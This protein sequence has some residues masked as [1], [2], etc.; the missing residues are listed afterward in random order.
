MTRSTVQAPAYD[1]YFYLDNVLAPT[2]HY[3]AAI[4]TGLYPGIVNFYFKYAKFASDYSSPSRFQ[5]GPNMTNNSISVGSPAVVP[6]NSSLTRIPVTVTGSTY[7][8]CNSAAITYKVASPAPNTS[9]GSE[10]NLHLYTSSSANG[11]TKITSSNPN[12]KL[13]KCIYAM[14]DVDKNGHVNSTDSLCIQKRYLDLVDADPSRTANEQEI[15]L[16]AFDLAADVDHDYS[17]TLLDVALLNSYLL[18]N[19]TL[20]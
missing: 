14:G 19:A 12:N 10:E 18:G 17:V 1:E 16:C 15:D 11:D 2:P 20:Y 9:F 13:T 3:I 4:G 8:G 7:V 5:L 6:S